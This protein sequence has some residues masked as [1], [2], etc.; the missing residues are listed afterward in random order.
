M[1]ALTASGIRDS[2]FGCSVRWL[3]MVSVRRRSDDALQVRIEAGA[4]ARLVRALRAEQH[5]IA[6]R[7]ET[8]RVV[9]RIAA[10][11]ADR[12]RLGD[13]LRDREQ[14]RHRLERLAEIVLV[15]SGH[16][17]A[18]AA[19]RQLVDDGRQVL[20]EELSFVDA[21]DLGVVLDELEQ[22]ARARDRARRNPHLA[23]RDDG[24]VRVPRVD[25]RLEDLHPLAGNLRAAQPADQ[26]LALAAEHA[27]DDDFDP[28]LIGLVTN[29]VHDLKLPAYGSASRPRQILAG[30]RADANHVARVDERRHA[31]DQTRSRPLPA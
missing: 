28:A 4:T 27:A 5:A 15:E 1:G 14:L 24:V 8:L 9:G 22:R 17:D 6:A 12:Q 25:H 31:D 13:V 11:H 10:H 23:V 19:V 26:L 29:Y 18:F 7:H 16:D 2:G 21:D 3:P 20:I 30:F